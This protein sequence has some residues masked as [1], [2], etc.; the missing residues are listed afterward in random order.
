[1]SGIL[2]EPLPNTRKVEV[3]LPTPINLYMEIIL[4]L[5]HMEQ[6]ILSPLLLEVIRFLVFVGGMGLIT[7]ARI[8][9]Q[10]PILI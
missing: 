10:I 4:T 3:V 5:V 8:Q 7:G 2:M 6:V 1:M 9:V